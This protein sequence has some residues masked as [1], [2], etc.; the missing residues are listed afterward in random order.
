[1]RV[2]VTGG[3]GFIGSNITD[4]LVKAGHEVCVVDSLTDH[5]GGRKEHV[6]REAR[7]TEID[8]RD[9]DALAATF[10]SFK[11]EIVCHHAAQHS[12]VFGA[13]DPEY[14]ADVNV[15]GTLRVLNA[16]VKAG[17]GKIL[18]ASTA[19]TFGN[20]ERLPID[21]ATPQRP[22]SPYGI[23]KLAA[24][25]YLRFFARQ[26]GLKHTIFR[27]GNVYGPRQNPHGEGGVVAIWTGKFIAKEG[28]QINWDGEQTRD[29]TFVHDIVRA[30]LMALDKG[31]DETFV[32]GTGRKT[33]VNEIYRVLVDITG[34][35]APVTRGP[36]R[37]SDA[38]DSCFDPSKA[39]TVLGW[40]AETTLADGLRRTVDYYSSALNVG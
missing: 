37:P 8:I 40:Q 24:E 16:A 21:E 2:V 12:V 38:R 28:V 5:G 17:V 4:A 22:I 34:F 9:G 19:A 27:Y 29:F 33:S 26:H 39:K 11:P 13:R 14:D 6:P 15:T 36:H 25:H 1:M 31:D 20:V 10:G 7:F 30:N 18:F 35:E 23:T 32:I 3:A